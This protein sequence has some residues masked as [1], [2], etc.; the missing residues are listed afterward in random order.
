MALSGPRA[1]KV[2]FQNSDFAEE[3]RFSTRDLVP[4]EVAACTRL[5]FDH[6]RLVPN[7][8]KLVGNNARC[9]VDDPTRRIGTTIWI[10]RFGKSVCAGAA[11][12]HATAT[13]L[14][15]AMNS[16]RSM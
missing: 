10:Y 12:G 1:I 15:A 6:D 9:D 4:G 7:L 8:R 13:P 16:R 2:K 3:F 5:R 14:T 11:S